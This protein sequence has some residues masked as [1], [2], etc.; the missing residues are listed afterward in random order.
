M[1]YRVSSDTAHQSALSAASGARRRRDH[2]LNCNVTIAGVALGCACLAAVGVALFGRAHDVG[3]L[4][5]YVASHKALKVAWVDPV[6]VRDADV[7]EAP[8][9]T[10]VARAETVEPPPPKA[11]IVPLPPKRPRHTIAAIVPLPRERPVDNV[12]TGSLGEVPQKVAAIPNAAIFESQ[13]LAYAATPNAIE[14]GSKALAYAVAPSP[15]PS[16]TSK[17]DLSDFDHVTLPNPGKPEFGRGEGE[18]VKRPPAKHAPASAAHGHDKETKPGPSLVRAKPQPPTIQEKLWGKP[19]RLASLTPLDTVRTDSSGLP[20]APYDRQTAV[21][22]IEDAKVYLPDGQ[23]L[24]AHSGLG[25]MMDDPRYVRLR[26][27]GATPPHVYDLTMREALFHGVEAIRMTPI[28]GEEAIFGRAGILAHT[29][30]LG[31]NGQS[32][33]CVSFRNYDAFLDAFKQGKISRMA[34]IARLD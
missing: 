5:N 20:R 14:A 28:G 7:A 29:Y 31:P 10:K 1:A 13:P 15:Q 2:S 18:L 16:P 34:V 32:N 12:A 19:V 22:V 23:V 24:E 27:R 3:S 21:Y 25:S 4:P 30:M 8:A 11:E 33:G 6:P 9:T 17:S 26:M